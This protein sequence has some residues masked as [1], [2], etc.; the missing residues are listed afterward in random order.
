MD[1]IQFFVKTIFYHSCTKYGEQ[2]TYKTYKEGYLNHLGVGMGRERDENPSNRYDSASHKI[3]NCGA[4]CGSE[5]GS[6]LLRTIDN[7]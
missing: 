6:K 5:V 1:K 2:E 7:K 4:S 3:R